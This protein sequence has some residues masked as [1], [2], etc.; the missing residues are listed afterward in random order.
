PRY[1]VSRTKEM[2]E[3]T[4][5]AVRVSAIGENHAGELF[6]MDHDF[7]TVHTLARSSEGQRN[8]DF[9]TSLSQTG[10]F[11][12]AA[13]H[14]PAAGVY[15]FVVNSQ[16][17]HDGATAEHWI[18]LPDTSSVRWYPAGKPIPGLVYW[19]HFRMHFPRDTVLVRTIAA[20]SRRIETQLLHYDGLDWRGY[21]YAWRDDQSDADLVPADGAEKDLRLG[22]RNVVWQFHSRT[23]CLSCHS[24]QSEYALAFSPEQL[25]R[26]GSDGHNQLVAFTQLGLIQRKGKNDEDLPAFDAESVSRERG[27]VDPA[28]EREPLEARA[29]AFLHANC[30]HCHSDHGGGTGPL[31]LQYSVPPQEMHA[32]GPRPTRGD[33]S[34]PDAEIIKPGEPLAS[35]LFFRMAKFGRD[36]MPHIGS[37]WPD[38]FGLRL[39]E[40][41]I[42]SLPRQDNGARVATSDELDLNSTASALHWARQLGRDALSADQRT[43]LLA[44]A[45]KLPVGPPR[46]LFEGFF[47]AAEQGERKL[48]SNPRPARILSLA[49]DAARGEQ[50]FWSEAV[51]CGKC[52]RVGERGAAVGPEL[53]S[54]GGQRTASDLL[55]SMLT[56]SRRIEPQYAAYL[57]QTA[58]GRLLTGVLVRRDDTQVILR[59]G[60][61]LE[62]TLA[63]RSVQ[64]LQPLRNSL[65]PDGQLSGLTAQQAADLLCYLT[66]LRGTLSPSQVGSR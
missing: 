1:A 45:A 55:E 48:G 58:D 43:V 34:L 37:E 53:S 14:R 35:T 32:I 25:N 5:P 61:G 22:G 66:G 60:Q 54:I 31:R 2:P 33:F 51:N 42:A 46:D 27:L 18:A 23:Q 13:E 7:G 50:M 6:Y 4:R 65:M 64:N 52:H 59:D 20:A 19:H 30:G 21:T 10:L 15:P 36:R 44:A 39:I 47:P 28:Y 57:V 41:W 49:G 3:K 62:I 26:P 8:A 11:A 16:Q 9:P 24:N 38:E 12:S 17:W 40:Q 63:A 29:R 56:P